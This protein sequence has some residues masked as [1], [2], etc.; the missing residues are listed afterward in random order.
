MRKKQNRAVQY[1]MVWY[2]TVR[3]YEQ[4]G[5]VWYGISIVLLSLPLYSYPMEP[6]PPRL[7]SKVRLTLEGNTNTRW[8][9]RLPCPDVSMRRQ[10]QETPSLCITPIIPSAQS[11]R[12]SSERKQRKISR[13]LSIVIVALGAILFFIFFAGV[14]ANLVQDDLHLM[15][16]Y[17][18]TSYWV[19]CLGQPKQHTGKGCLSLACRHDAPIT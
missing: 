8:V 12:P 3:V 10:L 15:Y 2:S 6:W 5:I 11:V 16:S 19:W 18:I 7:A 14:V 9:R 4:Y 17:M 1:G 13:Q